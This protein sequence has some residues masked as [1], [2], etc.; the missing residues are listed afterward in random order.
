[1]FI[2]K[3]LG[4]LIEYELEKLL[5]KGGDVVTPGPDQDCSLEV[6]H[7]SARDPRSFAFDRV[8]HSHATQEMVRTYGK[9]RLD[10]ILKILGGIFPRKISSEFFRGKF[11]RKNSAALVPRKNYCGNV[12][13]STFIECRHHHGHF[14]RPI[15]GL[16]FGF[17]RKNSAEKSRGL[18]PRHWCRGKIP[19]LLLNVS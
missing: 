1:M 7:K 11:P 3:R 9:F 4:L 18:V 10:T 17:P 5:K 15:V 19:G 12:G 6:A 16:G 13:V 2:L 8:F 14:F